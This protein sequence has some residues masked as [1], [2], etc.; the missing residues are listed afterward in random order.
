MRDDDLP[1]GYANY[2]TEALKLLV[3]PE[4]LAA[5]AEAAV[6]ARQQEARTGQRVAAQAAALERA[7]RSGA[8]E[9]RERSAAVEAMKAPPQPGFHRVLPRLW[10]WAD[11]PAVQTVADADHQKQREALRRHLLDLGPDRCIRRPPDWPGALGRLEQLLPNFT[12]P[13]DL[14]RDAL[15]LAQAVEFRSRL[16]PLLL[17]GPPGVGKTYFTH[18][19]AEMLGVSHAAIGFDQPSAGNQLRGSD[20]HW[21]NSEPGLLFKLLCLGESANP[22]VLLDELDKSCS[23][24]S[25]HG[26]DPLSQLHA[27]LEPQTARQLLDISVDME[28]DASLVSYVATANSVHGL[29]MPLLSRFEVFDIGPPTRHQAVEVAR[30][31]IATTLERLG[32]VERVRFA[33]RCA[34]VLSQL[35]PRLMCRTA[36]RLAGSALREGRELVDEESAWAALGERPPLHLH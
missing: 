10:Q 34:Y 3:L 33:P 30:H 24:S 18:C 25:R 15:T 31:V 11:T 23:S 4:A 7:A 20:K 32:L 19:L 26:P 13:L 36:E 1:A 14:L 12:A 5:E 6:L 16:P 21:S 8:S 29:G 35:S 27:A 2:R 28:M 9:A 17:L 22:L